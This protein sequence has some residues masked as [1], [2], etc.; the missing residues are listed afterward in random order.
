MVFDVS[1]EEEVL[2][3]CSLQSLSFHILNC[4]DKACVFF[5]ERSIL[6]FFPPAFLLWSNAFKMVQK[7]FKNARLNGYT[8]S[9]TE[10]PLRAF[11]ILI[12]IYAL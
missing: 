8:G 9:F 5:G 12:S 10:E 11:T 6:Y 1:G 2:T 7:S 4:L 3:Q